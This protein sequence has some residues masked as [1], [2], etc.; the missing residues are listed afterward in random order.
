[1]EKISLNRFL[2]INISLSLNTR[3]YNKV[4][5]STDLKNKNL[6]ICTQQV[7]IVHIT[8]SENSGVWNDLIPNFK[9]VFDIHLERNA[10]TKKK[11]F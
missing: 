3:F 11:G 5:K 1:M 4:F 2:F 8:F 6:H 10:K 7:Q 9:T